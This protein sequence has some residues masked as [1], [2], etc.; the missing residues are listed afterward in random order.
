MGHDEY[1]QHD[2]SVG[3][4]SRKSKRMGNLGKLNHDGGLGPENSSQAESKF[5]VEQSSSQTKCLLLLLVAM[6][7]IAYILLS[8]LLT[9]ASSAQS[10]NQ[11]FRCESSTFNS[12]LPAGVTI[13]M[14][15]EFAAGSTYAEPGNLGHPEEALNLTNV[16]AVTVRVSRSPSSY[17]F[18]LFLPTRCAWNSKFLAVGNYAQAGGINWADMAVGPHYGMATLSTDTGHSST[19]GNLSWG[20][21]DRDKLQDWGWR[22][23]KGSV[24]IGKTLVQGFYGK[25]I[26]YSYWSGCSTGGRQGLKQMQVAPEAFDGVLVGAPAW[27]TKHLFPWIA[28]LAALNRAGTAGYLG[29]QQLAILRTAVSTQCLSRPEVQN[30]TAADPFAGCVL[31]FGGFTCPNPDPANCLTSD[32]VNT[33]RSVYADWRDASGR[34][35]FPGMPLGSE[36]Q[37]SAYGL[38]IDLATNTS[39]PEFNGDYERY[40]LYNNPNWS[41]RNDWNEAQVLADSE[42]I[43]PGNATADQFNVS[44]FRERKGKVM[45]YHGTA[46]SVVPTGTSQ[47]YYDETVRALGGGS[48]D[49]FMRLFYVPGMYHCFFTDPQINAPWMMGGAGQAYQNKKFLGLGQGW[50]VPFFE[51]N[52][53]FDALVALMNWVENKQAVENITATTF[54]ADGGVKQHPLC[55]YPAKASYK[56]SGDIYNVTNWRCS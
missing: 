13:E 5:K 10:C 2:Q 56:G 34:L 44:Q 39:E 49:D 16:C 27:D 7:P 26:T 18:G 47:V 22:A 38:G 35:V 15:T 21:N 50:S 32:Q 29:A 14:A 8:L 3:L 43:N 24:E 53:R 9:S 4:V 46:D 28:R 41:V 23:L 12:F 52:R 40:W 36:A 11:T 48:V 51:N 25:D 54:N 37:W 55:K 1:A 19:Q 45:I 30:G 17:R 33:I 42:R 6:A 31:D 20:L